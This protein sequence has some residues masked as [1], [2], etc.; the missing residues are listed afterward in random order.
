MKNFK[1]YQNVVLLV[2]LLLIP[3]QTYSYHYY[4]ATKGAIIYNSTVSANRTLALGVNRYGHLNTIRDGSGGISENPSRILW[5]KATGLAYK[6]PS[7]STVRSKWDGNL[8]AGKW[9]DA[10]SPGCLCEGWGVSG[11]G[12]V[13]RASVDTGGIYGLTLDSFEPSIANIK[14]VTKMGPTSSRWSRTPVKDSEI[15]QITHDYGPAPE[16]Q[17]TLF[18]GLV[19][20][21]NI[22]DKKVTNVRYRRTM[23]WDIPNREF[24]EYVSHGGVVESMA[25]S[26]LPKLIQSCDN[27][28]EVPDP[29]GGCRPMDRRTANS[30]FDHSGPRDH[31]SSFTFQFPDLRCGESVS[32]MMY[33]GVANTRVKALE[34]IKAV[35]AEVYSLGEGAYQKDAVTFIFAFKGVSGVSLAT[36][37]PP[38]A[39]TLPSLDRVQVTGKILAYK[40][41]LYNTTFE[42]RKNQQWK[43]HLYRR[44]LIIDGDKKGDI[45]ISGAIDAGVLLN[46]KKS[47]KRNIWTATNGSLSSSGNNNNF[48]TSNRS[49]LKDAF[50]RNSFRTVDDGEVDDLINFIRGYDSYDENG[51][52]DFTDERDWKLADIY[53][54]NLVL[55][56]PPNNSDTS[57]SE[58]SRA[59]YKKTRT[60]PYSDFITANASRKEVIYAGANDGMLHAFDAESLEELWAFVPPPVLDKLRLIH[61]TKGSDGVKGKSNSI[62]LVDGT[63]TIKDIY[64]KGAD[65]EYKWRT[66]LMAGLGY[67]GKGYYAIDIT[68]PNNPSHLFSFLHDSSKRVVDYWAADGT[69]TT[70]DYIKEIVPDGL[71]YSKLSEAWT[72]PF[73]TLMPYKDE[74][75]WVAVL[76]G[77]YAGADE[78]SASYARYVYIIDLELDTSLSNKQGVVLKSIELASSSESDVANGVVAAISAISADSASSADY[79][80]I[81]AYLSDLQGKTW[82]LD[83]A[84]SDKNPD[85]D[86]VDS[87]IFI[88]ENHL[89]AQATLANDRLMYHK[90]T[91]SFID[92]TPYHYTG[93]GDIIRLQRTDDTIDNRVFGIRDTDFPKHENTDGT[94]S[95]TISSLEDGFTGSCPGEDKKGWY[96]D[97]SKI[98]PSDR[99]WSKVTAEVAVDAKYVYF[100]AYSPVK[101]D[102]CLVDGKSNLIKL[103]K[104][105]GTLLADGSSVIDLG[106]GIVGETTIYK[107]KS[108][109]VVSNREDDAKAFEGGAKDI[110]KGEAEEG[111]GGSVAI[112]PSSISTE[113]WRQVF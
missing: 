15:L 61:N 47:A 86:K 34:A 84:H 96:Q 77:G 38:K 30:N 110:Y 93:T 64:Y 43:G 33:Y 10:T 28:F 82:K 85:I 1:I 32:F 12:N 89:D 50:Y 111:D 23:D 35:G 79:Y 65:G 112:P 81:L 70:Y 69:L 53:H 3:M 31:G 107:G 80:G 7:S 49:V 88:A 21:S 51:G 55:S 57:T 46:L 92:G 39:A 66:V 5:N 56:I 45:S 52:G 74:L 75:K 105:C 37:L 54:A 90:L 63:P 29:L 4:T 83:L 2:S 100:S 87:D 108:Y 17:H 98:L 48:I 109:T 9:Q 6:W 22:S 62:Y 73:I 36:D 14:S 103:E 19:T 68:D 8:L 18:Q 16:A 76:G 102:S 24:R 13:G 60:K 99:K 41:R 42:Y 44:D 71:N 58:K 25:A 78:E 11:N 72:R 106:V 95:Y 20:I 59:Y 97:L 101:S 91:N 26:K 104:K 27:G 40:D 67:G 113:S 94:I